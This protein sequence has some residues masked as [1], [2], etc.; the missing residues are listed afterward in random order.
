MLLGAKIFF[1][2][3][4]CKQI[5]LGHNQPVLHLTK[6]GWILSG[7]INLGSNHKQN[8]ICNLALVDAE[9][10]EQVK[11]FWTI[12]E[13]KTTQKHLTRE[14][15]ECETYFLQSTRRD[16]NGRFEISLPLQKTYTELGSS[17][18]NALKRLIHIETI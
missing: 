2:V 12:E 6:L 17:E 16:N 11:R 3:L 13:I 18:Q 10:N 5:Y 14:E 9:L 7:N 15:Q 8:S 4:C 1:D